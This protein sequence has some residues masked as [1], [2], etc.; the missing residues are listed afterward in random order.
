MGWEDRRRR[1]QGFIT[2][3]RE[4]RLLASGEGGHLMPQ[5]PACRSLP[6]D[7]RQRLPPPLPAASRMGAHLLGL[8]LVLAPLLLLLLAAP[9]L[10]LAPLLILV[11]VLAL[12]APLPVP[13]LLAPALGRS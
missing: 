13:L 7:G 12:A 6:G 3:G 11:L 10:L 9:L 4:G 1:R 8:G 2:A 5:A